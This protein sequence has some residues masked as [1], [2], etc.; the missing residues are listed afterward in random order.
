M[1]KLLTLIVLMSTIS[2]VGFSD[3]NL[4]RNQA[5]HKCDHE[6]YERTNSVLTFSMVMA[7]CDREDPN[8]L[9]EAADQWKKSGT[10]GFAQALAQVKAN[11]K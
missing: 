2:T 6:L 4:E 10:I 5:L 3:S 11:K 7:Y 9:I 1:Q 8:D